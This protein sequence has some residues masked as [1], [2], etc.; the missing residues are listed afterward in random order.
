MS[1][2][3][4]IAVMLPRD[5]RADR[6]REFVTTAEQLGFDE[7]WVV[8]DLGFRGGV[9]QAATVLAWT[10]HIR[11]GL[12][13]LPAAVRNPAFAAME[14]ATLAALFPGRVDVGMG[15]GLPGWMREVG[16]WPARPLTLLEERVRA[17]RALV[18]GEEGAG[19]RLDP[20][21]VPDAAPRLMLGVRGPRSLALSGR[22]ADGT[23]LAEPA[24]PEYVR[25][26]LDLIDPAGPHRVV[27]YNVGAVADDAADAIGLA[28][29]ALEW[30]G[31]PDWA[32]HLSDL[33]FR[34]E[35]VAVR[36][37]SATRADFAA[38]LPDEWVAELALAGTPDQ[39]RG[40]IAAL[41]E[42][43]VSSSVFIPAGPDPV[44]ALAD[45]AR[46]L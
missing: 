12:G 15:H 37:A 39:V 29:P 35:L 42:A 10:E 8:E 44:A 34:D 1:R 25:A 5:L 32:T 28:R 2:R 41:G 18:A 23:I 22:I 11:V 9:A 3:P 40:R 30:I 46:V 17:V 33:P 19:T 6:V 16:T 14:V 26:S 13:I 21:V 43:G 7:V 4:D 45:L 27:T 20:A 24:T 36:A 38:A 31:E